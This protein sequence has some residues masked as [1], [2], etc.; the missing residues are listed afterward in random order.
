MIACSE[1]LKGLT[2]AIKANFPDIVTQ[3]CI[4][5]QIRNTMRFIAVKDKKPFLK[6]LRQVYYVIDLNQSQNA[7]C[8]L[9]ICKLTQQATEYRVSIRPDIC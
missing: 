3:L 1:N 8:L 4:V 7:F 6:N 9:D 5:H 2:Q